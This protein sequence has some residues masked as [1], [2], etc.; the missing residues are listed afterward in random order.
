MVL[1]VL[2]EYQ[3]HQKYNEGAI[4]VHRHRWCI[5]L[6][7]EET[8]GHLRL[9]GSSLLASVNDVLAPYRDV[10]L[11]D[12]FPF[13]QVRPTHENIA[14]YLFN[15]LD[16][17][18]IAVQHCLKGISISEDFELINYLDH[19]SPDFDQLLTTARISLAEQS[20]HQRPKTIES[21]T[22]SKPKRASLAVGITNMM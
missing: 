20:T 12:V 18:L 3:H 1:E 16:D 21:R 22:G 13:N 8:A 15:I 10:V 7:V 14:K 5:N 19:R 11:N 9:V 2:F 17:T 6:E 4:P